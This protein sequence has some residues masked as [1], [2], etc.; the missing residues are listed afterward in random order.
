MYGSHFV[1]DPLEITIFVVLSSQTAIPAEHLA[2]LKLN[3]AVY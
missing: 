2:Y 1:N 3:S